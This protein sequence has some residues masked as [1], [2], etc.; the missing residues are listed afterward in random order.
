[1]PVYAFT[2][3]GCGPFE[4]VRPMREASAPAS[5]PACGGDA[6][7]VYTPPGIP[8]LAAPLRRALD[9]EERSTHEPEVVTTKT[10]KPL[11]HRHGP[12]PPWVLSH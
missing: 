6:R 4:V 9:R 5:C 12:T 10:G 11:P 7:R 1:M 3:A 2:C 8:L